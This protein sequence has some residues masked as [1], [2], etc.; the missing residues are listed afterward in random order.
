[1]SLTLPPHSAAAMAAAAPHAGAA[2]RQAPR[3]RR[4]ERAAGQLGAGGPEGWREGGELR[5]FGV[6]GERGAELGCAEPRGHRMW[7][8]GGLGRANGA[9]GEHTRLWGGS[10]VW[11]AGGRGVQGGCRRRARSLMDGAVWV[12]LRVLRGKRVPQ[13]RVCVL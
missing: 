10:S 11:G 3:M 9:G 7:A 12:P 1:M 4:A 5:G 2:L 6:R 8:G 13:S